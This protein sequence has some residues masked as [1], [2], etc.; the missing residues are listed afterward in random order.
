MKSTRR[1]T[2]EAPA[3]V[4]LPVPST[5]SHSNH[6]DAISL[7]SSAVPLTAST[8]GD[9][10]QHTLYG[11]SIFHLL[12]SYNYNSTL[13]QYPP[14]LVLLFFLPP[15]NIVYHYI[16]NLSRG[17]KCTSGCGCNRLYRTCSSPRAEASRGVTDTGTGAVTGTLPTQASVPCL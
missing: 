11:S 9:N 1:R 5:V 16:C 17:R 8:P 4:P 7:P 10:P 12:S 3:T 15:L 13:F 6:N 2:I 14:P